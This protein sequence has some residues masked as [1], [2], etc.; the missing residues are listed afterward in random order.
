MTGNRGRKDDQGVDGG[1]AERSVPG[2]F[3]S[4]VMTLWLEP[5]NSPERAEW[6]WRVVRTDT[7]ERR[8]FRRLKDVVS[9]VSSETGVEGPK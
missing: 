1:F 3:P 4:F 7:G 8:Y 5:S 9:Y 2:R 6:R